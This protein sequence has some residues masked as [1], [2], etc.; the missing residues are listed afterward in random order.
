M[1]KKLAALALASTALGPVLGTV[2]NAEVLNW[3]ATLDQAQEVDKAAPAPDAKGTAEGTLDTDSG[4]LTWTV[5]YSGLSADPTG[6]HLH[7]PAAMGADAPV[8][9][10]I[11]DM[12]GLASPS[13]GSTT[14][15]PEG[16]KQVDDGMWYINIHTPSNPKG[17]I[18]GQVTISK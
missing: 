7:G 5:T 1:L 18:R 12:S 16:I 2:A 6:M 13:T 14:L 3:T 8:V 4:A 10:N 11:G 15:A 9:V 17:E